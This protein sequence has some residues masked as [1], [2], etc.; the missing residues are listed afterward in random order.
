MY[1]S[2]PDPEATPFFDGFSDGGPPAARALLSF[3][4]A[5]WS[6]DRAW[7][8]PHFYFSSSFLLTTWTN[9]LTCLSTSSLVASSCLPFLP[10][11]FLGFVLLCLGPVGERTASSTGSGSSF[12]GMWPFSRAIFVIYWMYWLPFSA[13]QRDA[14]SNSI[15]WGIFSNSGN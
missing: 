14:S 10:G 7:K 15:K 1:F 4:L 11:P 13:S 3:S 2:V 8:S 6:T 9:S 5:C 12:G